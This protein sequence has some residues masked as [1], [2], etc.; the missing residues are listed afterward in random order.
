MSR[1]YIVY[2]QV[3]NAHKVSEWYKRQDKAAW[4][5]RLVERLERL[6]SEASRRGEP[7]SEHVETLKVRE[8]FVCLSVAGARQA[9]ELG[10]L[11]LSAPSL[12]TEP[13]LSLGIGIAS[14][15]EIFHT[16][17]D[18]RLLAEKALPGEVVACAA[19]HFRPVRSDKEL[20]SAILGDMT[21][22]LA[23]D[24]MVIA[25]VGSP[26]W[27]P[28]V[29]IEIG[30]RMATRNPIVFVCDALENGEPP[31]D[32]H[33]HQFVV[34]PPADQEDDSTIRAAISTLSR[35]LEK[36][37]GEARK[38]DWGS[39]YPFAEI[40]VDAVRNQQL[41]LRATPEGER[42]FGKPES[43][44]NVP[45]G[46]VVE[47]IG[48]LMPSDQY[49]AFA[50][51]QQ[52]LIGRL[53]TLAANHGEAL[54]G[55]RLRPATPADAPAITALYLGC[56]PRADGREP[57]QNYPYPQLLNPAWVATALRRR[58]IQVLVAERQGRVC[59]AVAAAPEAATGGGLA[60]FFGL[61]IDQ[62]G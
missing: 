52:A 34:L 17:T 37:K 39:E 60:E 42:L 20:S 19:E 59:G 54:R 44:K 8:E 50:K 1:R 49:E 22:A 58:H 4:R 36:K 12:A 38:S 45:V 29:M 3:R 23:M 24:P 32:L 57:A 14:G 55:I 7:K 43:L 62:G 51:K 48:G 41:F 46:E 21:A 9:D 40:D 15:T 5:E 28:N 16:A 31:F 18:A 13:K 26:P 11:I 61:V 10:S 35:A 2:V 27:N 33:D 47:W 6:L 30:Y 56:Y 25:Y 53:M